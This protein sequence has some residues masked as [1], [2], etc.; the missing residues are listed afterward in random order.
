MR[1]A[2]NYSYGLP[3]TD[4]SAMKL[5][6]GF[7]HHKITESLDTTDLRVTEEDLTAGRSLTRN[8]LPSP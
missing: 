8:L 5:G 6:P 7:D 4:G 2:L 3:T 1:P